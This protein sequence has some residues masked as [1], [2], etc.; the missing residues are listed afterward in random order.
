M[1]HQNAADDRYVTT[2]TRLATNM[3]PRRSN[4]C[5]CF[6]ETPSV[7]KKKSGLSSGIA[8]PSLRR[9]CFLLPSPLILTLQPSV[10][11][12]TLEPFSHSATFVRHVQLVCKVSCFFFLFFKITATVCSVMLLLFEMTAFCGNKVLNIRHHYSEM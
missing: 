7:Y 2:S 9:H 1:Y 4:E 5:K 3:C 12:P 8:W 11:F 10:S 6:L